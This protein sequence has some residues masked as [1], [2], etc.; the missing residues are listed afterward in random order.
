MNMYGKT[1]RLDSNGDIVINELKRLEMV[2][3]LD[4]VA[5]DVSVI[6]KT[7][8]G[9]FPLD[10]DFGV[11]YIRI[12]ESGFSKKV[13]KSEIRRALSRYPYLKSIDSIE[14]SHPDENR[15]VAVSISLTVTSGESI[16]V[17]VLL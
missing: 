10:P 3:G 6:L 9:S 16:G 15:H 1:F 2:E 4:K 17:E 11:D 7:V 5:Q 14:V 8:R 13:I 12:V